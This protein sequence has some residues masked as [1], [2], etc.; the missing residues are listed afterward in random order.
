MRQA[1]FRPFTIHMADRREIDVPHPD[2]VAYPPT[3]RP[4]I[5]VHPDESY[6][7]LDLLLMSELQVHTAN[8]HAT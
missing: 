7:V 1:P 2:F 4:V 6:S 8:G 3:G 5:V